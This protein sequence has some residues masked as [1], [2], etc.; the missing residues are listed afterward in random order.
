[1]TTPKLKILL[2]R[3]NGDDTHALTYVK[4]QWFMRYR[5]NGTPKRVSLKTK[6]FDVAKKIRDSN[7]AIMIAKGATTAK[8]TGRKTIKEKLRDDPDSGIGIYSRS[9]Y[10]VRVRG[11]V[12]IETDDY[13]LAKKTRNEY[14][15]G[16]P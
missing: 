12:I 16:L 1:M 15:E 11:V 3:P 7:Y 4:G 10:I 14:V 9:P 2:P 5:Q 13:E 6:E 8:G